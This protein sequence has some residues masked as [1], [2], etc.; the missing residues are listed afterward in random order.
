M[1]KLIHGNNIEVMLNLIKEGLLVDCI[2]ADM[3]YENLDFSWVSLCRHLLKDNGIIYIQTDYH[4]VYEL[5]LYMDDMFGKDNFINHLIYK[6]EWGGRSLRCF[7]KKHDD[8]LMYSKGKDYKFYYER[9]LIPKV[10]AG[11]NLDKRGDGLKIPCDVFD[12]LGNFSTISKERVKYNGTN[13][14][15]QKSLKLMNRLLLPVT[16]ENDL[17]LDPFIGSGT[18]GVW[19]KQNNRDFIGI[20]DNKEIFDLAKKRIESA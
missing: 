16:D 4:S 8:I 10:T 17:V 12:D 19:C 9:I 13:I 6:Q 15:W 11:T 20:E 14:K 1:I 3:V 5:K 18:T 7:P 2:Y